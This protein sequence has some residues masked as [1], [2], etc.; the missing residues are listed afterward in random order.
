MLEQAQYVRLQ[1][2]QTGCNIMLNFVTTSHFYG[3][4]DDIL[5]ALPAKLTI[6]WRRR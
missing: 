3:L 4:L 6:F 5:I 2:A 1:H